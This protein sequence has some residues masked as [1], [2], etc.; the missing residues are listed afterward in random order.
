[1]SETTLAELN[2]ADLAG[3]M[4]RLGPLFEHSPWVAEE[5]FP[6]RP[7]RDAKQLHAELCATMHRAARDRRVALIRGASRPG[8]THGPAHRRL[9]PGARPEPGLTSSA[10]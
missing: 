3:F 9:H 7:F 2:A 5:T 4:A 8:R 1:M 6:R 10:R